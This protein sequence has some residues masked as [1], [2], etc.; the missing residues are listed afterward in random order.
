MP[1]F[2]LESGIPVPVERLFEWH[3]RPDAFERLVP[4][5]ERVRLVER[6]GSLEDGSRVVFEFRLGPLRRRWVSVHRDYVPG[7]QFRDK[8]V[9]G[10]F[11]AWS[12]LHR[13]EPAGSE[14]S[15]LSDRVDYQLPLAP[16][17]NHV[18]GGLVRRKLGQTFAWRHARVRHDLERHTAYADRPRLRVAI[19]GAGGVIG[20]D[21]AT[22]LTTGGHEVLRLV[23]RSPSSPDEIR[24]DPARREIDLERLE[25]LD[26]VVHLCGRRIDTRWTVSTRAEIRDSRIE[27]TR[28]LSESLARLSAPPTTL[29][30]ASAV[31]VYGDRGDEVLTERSA[32]GPGF[33]A[34]LC[35]AWEASTEPAA[36]AGM[37]VITLRTG[38]VITRRGP[39]LT[40]LLLPFR[41]GLGAVL[42]DGEQYIG[43]VALDDVVAAILHLLYAEELRGP[44]NIV[45][46]N[47]VTNRELTKMLAS[48]IGRPSV[49]RAPAFAIKLLVGEMGE[50]TALASQRAR[51]ET[52]LES[53][54]QFTY[55]RLDSLLAS[56]LPAPDSR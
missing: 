38:V 20:S 3:E 15:T 34:E 45:G 29:V 16:I 39:P 22:F 25:G 27:S 37:R 5:W 51:P 35:Q 4:P 53:G 32:P 9:E 43:W 6:P 2:S 46:P 28:F 41:L 49:L 33:L 40:R 23:R 12:H 31:G 30:S 42:G 54:Y 24:W 26:G 19:S 55:D 10:P 44:V 13:F 36:A 21:L 48:A 47:P 17:A 14:F 56:E 52:L 11:A 18:A 8:Q 1:S 50:Q 7:R